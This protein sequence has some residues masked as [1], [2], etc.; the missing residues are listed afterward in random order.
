MTQP[1]HALALCESSLSP[2]VQLSA[3]FLRNDYGAC[4][5]GLKTISEAWGK[6]ADSG[7]TEPIVPLLAGHL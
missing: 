3:L 7:I 4:G 2:V 1:L 6:M 5:I